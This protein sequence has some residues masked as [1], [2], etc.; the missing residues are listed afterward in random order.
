MR[1]SFLSVI[2]VSALVA[3][4]CSSESRTAV[5]AQAAPTGGPGGRGGGGGGVPVTVGKVVRKT[6]PVDLR[7]IGSVEPAQTV[8]I[9]AQITGQLFSVGFK[10]GD[11]VKQGDVLFTLDKR[12]LEAALKQAEAN[13]Q[14]DVAQSANA[15]VQAQ[16]L[17]DLA[18]RGIVSKDQLDTQKATAAALAGTIEA[19]RAAV[20]NARIQIQYATIAAP[21]T[22]RTGRLMVHEGSL[23]RANDTTAMVVINQLTPINVEFAIPEAQLAPLKRYMQ[24]G[25][26]AVDVAPPSDPTSPSTGRVTFIDNSVDQTTGTIKVKGTFPNTNLLLWPGQFVNVVL[27]LSADKDAIVAPSAAIQTGQDG[28]YVF[29]VKSDQSAELRPVHVGRAAG[30]ETIVTDG[31]KGD[32]VVV[33]D[34]HLRLTPG[35]KVAVRSEE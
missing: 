10:E 14:R 32:E 28:Q 20:E 7:V 4:G 29:V 31:L 17:S 23:I 9:R 33:T 22:G 24:Q 1:R 34:G 19:D 5:S 35:I 25:H 26:V 3:A 30:T 21:L 27:T 2:L 12:P 18:Q 13:L 11:D 16:R 6:M 15:D 8:E